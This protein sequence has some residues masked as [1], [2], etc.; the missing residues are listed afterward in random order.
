MKLIVTLSFFILGV[1]AT[2]Q[3]QHP[4]HKSKTVAFKTEIKIE[5]NTSNELTKEK[6]EISDKVLNVPS[7]PSPKQLQTKV[8]KEVRVVRDNSSKPS[9]SEEST[10]SVGDRVEI[11]DCPG[12][13]SWASPFT[14][15]A[16]DGQWAKLEMV[17]ELVEIKKLLLYRSI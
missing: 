8:D 10:I 13:W 16:I 11:E 7:L 3:E 12:H 4:I 14:V 15:E 2:A 9:L 1:F 17:S 6:K 5:C